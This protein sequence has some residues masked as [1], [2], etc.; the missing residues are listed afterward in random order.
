MKAPKP[1]RWDWEWDWDSER[2]Q[3]YTMLKQMEKTSRVQ[4][5]IAGNRRC[6]RIDDRIVRAMSDEQRR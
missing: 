4:H 1:E 2:Q 6:D 3:I 5:T